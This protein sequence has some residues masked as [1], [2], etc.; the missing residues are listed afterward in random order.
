MT[1]TFWYLNHLEGKDN[2][3]N[4]WIPIKNLKS[5]EK[6]EDY[7]IILYSLVAEPYINDESSETNAHE[8][9]ATYIYWSILTGSAECRQ[10]WNMF[11]VFNITGINFQQF[12]LFE[13]TSEK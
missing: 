7:Y 1:Y 10:K 5:L 8:P 3:N 4:I 13:T 9:W 6:S 12:L 2:N 11:I